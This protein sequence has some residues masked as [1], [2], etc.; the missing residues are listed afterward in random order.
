[1]NAIW[2]FVRS[3]VPRILFKAFS[4]R[5]IPLFGCII[6]VMSCS[7]CQRLALGSLGLKGRNGDRCHAPIIDSLTMI[8]LVWP[9]LM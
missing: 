5:E 3:I 2:T 6:A 1:M 9:S 4:F 8:R 7:N